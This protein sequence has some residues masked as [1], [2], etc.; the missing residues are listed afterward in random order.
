MVPPALAISDD[1][2]MDQTKT[3]QVMNALPSLLIHKTVNNFKSLDL[4]VVCNASI[5]N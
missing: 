4:E 1:R 2:I 3:T 5:D